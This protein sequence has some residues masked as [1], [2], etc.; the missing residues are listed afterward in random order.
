MIKPSYMCEMY[1]LKHNVKSLTSQSDVIEVLDQFLLWKNRVF[2]SYGRSV[3]YG[4]ENHRS[5]LSLSKYDDVFIGCVD[6]MPLMTCHDVGDSRSRWTMKDV[7][8]ASVGVLGESAL[9]VTEKVVFLDGKCCVVKRFRTV[10]V[11]R[12]EFGR[13]VARLASFGQQCDYLVP[14]N[15]YL[16]SKRFKFV[17]C[18]YYPIGSLHDL[19]LGARKHG[20]TPLNWRQ[21]FKIIF[22]TAKAIAFIHSQP[23]QDKN[24]VINVHGNLKASNIMVDADFG[25]RLA[26]YGFTQLA[27]DIHETSREQPLSPCSPLPPKNM[28]NKVLSQK[29]DIYDYGLILL[30]ILGGPKALDS[31]QRVFETK[32]QVVKNKLGFFEFPFEGKDSAQVFKVLDIALACIHSL[33]QVRPTIDNILLYLCKK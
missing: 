16:Y 3:K 10:C 4:E 31:R 17:V 27:T 30:D 13:R 29:H 24:M 22:Q 18:D 9:G 33:P 20:H 32:E 19:L 2:L 21:R 15:A 23:P 12:K 26:N 5:S 6:D 14:V 28:S 1:Y 8:R 7:M 11:G 25:I